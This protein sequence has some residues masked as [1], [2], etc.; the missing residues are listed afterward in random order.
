MREKLIEE[1]DVVL[2]WLLDRWG[3]SDFTLEG[4]RGTLIAG[5]ASHLY[6]LLRGI[7]S[8]RNR[9]APGGAGEVSICQRPSLLAMGWN[10]DG[11]PLRPSH[12]ASFPVNTAFSFM[13]CKR[14]VASTHLSLAKTP[15]GLTLLC[16][17]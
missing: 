12:L 4:E 8:L 11:I 2:V 1:I 5:I 9:C 13:Q 17:L 16:F 10:R 14:D 15:S 7:R 3:A 6:C